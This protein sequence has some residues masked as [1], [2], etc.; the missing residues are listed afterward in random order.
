MLQH[1]ELYKE[2]EAGPEPEFSPSLLI[3]EAPVTGSFHY[4]VTKRALDLLIA[5]IALLLLLPLF[6]AVAL[7]IKLTSPGPIFYRWNVI[8]RNGK[9]F[10]GY[11]FRSMVTNA[12]KIKL[13]LLHLNEMQGPVFKIGNDPRITSV[14]RFLRKYS[15]DELPQ[16]WSVIKGDMSLVGPRPAFPSEWQSY[17]PW[18]RRKLSVVPGITCLWQVNGRNQ[19]KAFDDWVKLDLEYIDH[20]SLSADLKILAKTLPAVLR[21][22]GV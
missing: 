4:R 21:G 18:Q 7:L 11:K 20:W 9:P 15:L 14:G 6:L 3:A 16:L 8:G 1:A 17:Q 5:G 13:E 12:D 19:I 2:V 22:T 10:R